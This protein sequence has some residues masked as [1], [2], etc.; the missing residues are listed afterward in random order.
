VSKAMI[1]W[2]RRRQVHIQCSSSLDTNEHN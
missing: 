2:K 1:E